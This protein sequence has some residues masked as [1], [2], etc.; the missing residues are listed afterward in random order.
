MTFEEVLDQAID[1]L[2]RRGRV[3]YRALKRQFDLDDAYLEDL[4]EELIEGQQV[5][6][7]ENGKVLVWTGEAVSPTAFPQ[8]PVPASEMASTQ[9]REPL[10]YTPPHLA[11]KILT[12]RSALE[13]E[14]K[15]V[16]VLFADTAG[17]TALARRLD[18]EVVHEVMDRCF[19]LVTAEVH[20]FEGTIN[21]YTGDGVM[22]L[23]GAPI[24]HED[25]PRRAVYAALGIQ[26]AIRDFSRE[27]Q[28][29]RDFSVQMRLGINTGLVVVGKIGDDLRMDY[30]A[31]G[32]TTNLAARLQQLAQ[33]GTVVISEATHRLVA[34]LFETR[35]LGEHVVKG[36]VEPV[37]AFEVLQA[38]GR[39]TRLEVAA[40]HGLT[41]YVGRVRE[42]ATLRDLFLQ[43]K[44]GHGQVVSITGEAC[45]GKSRLVLELRRVLAAAGENVTWLEGQCLGFGQTMPFLPVV[46]QLRTNFGL[47]ETDGEPEIIAKIEEGMRRIGELESHIPAIRYLLAVDPGDEALVAMEPAAR[48]KR[49]VDAVLA[50]SLRGAQRQPLV[51]IYEDL[52]WIDASTEALLGP[53]IDAVVG[54]PLMLLLTYRIGY[55]PPFGSRSFHTTLTLQSLTAPETLAMASRLL[56]TE[57]FPEELTPVL[58]EKTEGVPLFVEEV[59]K[60]LQDIGALQREN[61]GYRVM[62]ERAA[63]SVPDTMQEIIMARLDRLGE[64]SK[65]TVQLA[66]VIGRQFLVRLL[67][68][69]ADITTPLE[70]LLAELQTLEI[71]YQQGL[72]PEPAYVFKHAVIQ[73]VAYNSLLVRRRKELHRAVGSAI[74][75]LYA[76]HLAEHYAELAHHFTQ[77][78]AW[79]KAIEYSVL[80]GDRAAAAYA[81]AE[82]RQ[83]YSRALE[84]VSKLAP[85]PDPGTLASFHK[86]H[87]AALT[88]LI[89]YEAAAAEYQRA[90][91]LIR[92]V[93]DRRREIEIL[94]G[95][96]NLYNFYHRPEPAMAYNDQALALSRE[97]GDQAA[98]AGGLVIRALIR[99]T[100]YGQILEAMPDAEEA[101]RL[102]RAVGDPKLLAQALCNLGTALQW[103]AE[104]GRGLAYLHEGAELA[105]RAHAGFEFGQAA[106]FIGN[107]NVAK[108]EYEEALRWYRRLSEYASG[109]GDK[110]WRARVPNLIGGL[111]LELFDLDEAL[112]LNLEAD[113]VAQQLSP[114]PEPRGHS[115]LKVGLAHLERGEHSHAEAFFRRAW[116]FL[117]EDLFLRWRW[118]IPLLRARG[119][120]ALAEGRLDEA[121]SFA[122]QSL[123]MATQTDSRK[124]VVRAQ[125]LQGDVLA[126]S[127]RLAEAAQT[128]TASVG[129]AEQIGTRR[130]VWLGNAA[131]GKV[132]A[133]L[134][135]EKDAEVRFNQ[136]A[137]NVEETVANLKTPR[138]R[139]SFLNATPVLA[140]YRVLGHHPPPASR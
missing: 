49:L 48:R 75:E 52:H 102:S 118:H 20:R 83:H 74:E 63:I 119:E 6:V 137:Q 38:R 15:Q 29:Q 105:Q 89:E 37:H 88:A 59:T 128:L 109:A 129:V 80:A 97:L 5:A 55:T 117:E 57:R 26:R 122:T 84:A 111:H 112:R 41:P 99:L 33:P 86:K 16:T 120:L 51:L 100:S 140:L 12:S 94:A 82:A 92:R 87:A 81:N 78:E 47:E 44:A 62:P 10:S 9:A 70:G 130:E 139:H 110:Y 25:S 65:R 8:A 45:I 42:L 50:L 106:F 17:F 56:G 96:S 73:D 138:L 90:L 54:G 3:T 67:V 91:E 23:F 107:A 43:V 108:G 14:R 61:G 131:L 1:M 19:K 2:R 72:L 64:D 40:E 53:L 104:F 121:W 39:L 76:D 30:T 103:R 69:I 71:I 79:E 7:D 68:R 93:G 124:H 31:M 85:V 58:L 24:A 66:S 34:G 18:P 27:L 125:L 101:L 13:G 126:A 98:Q 115:L 35:D 127:G 46:D 21:Q 22:A 133:Q 113:E 77:G 32:D 95:L 114:W 36:Y 11:E 132:L 135:Q 60:T 134:G 4:K 28:A 123:E 136:A 116:A